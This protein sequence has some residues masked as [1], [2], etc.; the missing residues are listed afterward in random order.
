M[1]SLECRCSEVQIGYD[2]GILEISN[3]C[4]EMESAKNLE[5]F[6]PEQKYERIFKPVIQHLKQVNKDS[7]LEA[8][9]AH[10]LLQLLSFTKPHINP[11]KDCISKTSRLLI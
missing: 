2:S 10:Y 1:C 6:S 5:L 8:V 3:C 9:T 11:G 4:D 7:Q